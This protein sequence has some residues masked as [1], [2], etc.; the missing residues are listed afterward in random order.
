VQN[1]ESMLSAFS[2]SNSSVGSVFTATTAI[3]YAANDLNL[4][5]VTLTGSDLSTTQSKLKTMGY[6]L[7]QNGNAT[8]LKMQAAP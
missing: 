2:L 7:I 3:E 6:A 5:S 8:S 4:K 1:F